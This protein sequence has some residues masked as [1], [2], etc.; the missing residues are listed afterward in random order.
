MKS[1]KTTLLGLLL[2]II[3]LATAVSIAFDN[4]QREAWNWHYWT[5]PSAF[6]LMGV[7]LFFLGFYAR[8]HTY[9]EK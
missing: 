1:W 8:D 2:L 4:I 3:C 7:S 5:M 6:A 9:R